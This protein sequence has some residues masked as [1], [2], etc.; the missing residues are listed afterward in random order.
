MTTLSNKILESYLCDN[1]IETG[2]YQGE[3]VLEAVKAGFK[4]IYSVELHKELFEAAV[5]KFQD[6]PNIEIVNGDSASMLAQILSKVDS[7]ATFWLDG[8]YSG[9]HTAKGLKVSPVMEELAQIAKHSIKTH[10]ILI[11]DIRYVHTGEYEFTMDE[12]ISTLMSINN[13]YKI[14]YH[15]GYQKDDILIAS[16]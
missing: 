16:I 2:T 3:G 1:F 15:D 6:S 10:N 5:I 13:K 11:D 8:H 14:S 4:N 9:S 7:K 12:L